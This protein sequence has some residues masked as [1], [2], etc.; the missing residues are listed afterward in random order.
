MGIKSAIEMGREFGT[1]EEQIK[2]YLI[3]KFKITP[4]YAQNCLDAEWEEDDIYV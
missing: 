3:K 1:P 2:E 4:E